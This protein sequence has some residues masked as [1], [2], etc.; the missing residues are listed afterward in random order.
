MTVILCFCFW[1][2]NDTNVKWNEIYGELLD[3]KIYMVQFNDL[4][5]W[6][7]YFVAKLYLIC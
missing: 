7:E 4:Q 1:A 3:I 6:G 2:M 5:L